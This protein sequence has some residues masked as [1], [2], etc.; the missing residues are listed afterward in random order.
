MI[1]PG[2]R[3]NARRWSRHKPPAENGRMRHQ[4]LHGAAELLRLIHNLIRFGTI[5]EVD[6]SRARVRVK[7]GE[8]LTA[9]LPWIEGRAGTTRDWDPPTTGEQVVLFS[10]GGDP[11]AGVVLTGIFS[12]KHAAPS[13]NAGLWRRVMPDG[14]VLEYDHANRHLNA[15]LPGSATITAPGGVTINANVT[16]NGRL[17]IAGDGVTHNGKN[18]GDTHRHGGVESGPSNTGVPT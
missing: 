3:D 17:T 13:D 18:I 7:S 12:Q 4:P 14:A 1:V 9:W 16:L 15:D 2:T 10:P 11:S 6:H 8:L 5:A